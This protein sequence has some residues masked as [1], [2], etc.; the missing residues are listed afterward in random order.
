MWL[1]GRSKLLLE[2]QSLRAEN[3]SQKQTINSLQQ[4]VD[5]L[6][7][8]SRVDNVIISGLNVQDRP[9]AEAAKATE[10]LADGAP[11]L[12]KEKLEDQVLNFMQE[13]SIIIPKHAI[14][15]C[16]FMPT[17]KTG[18]KKIIMRFAIRKEKDALLSQWKKL[19]GTNVFLN[20]HLTTK[21]SRLA[22]QL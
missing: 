6:E 15:T 4:R 22:F 3:L 13:Q 17:K 18:P 9:Y 21:T 19:D 7:Q 14:S 5:H 20:E 12:Q 8:Y 1:G 11:P 2:I 10:Q 16:H